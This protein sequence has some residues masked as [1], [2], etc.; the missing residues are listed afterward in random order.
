MFGDGY[1]QVKFGGHP[2]LAHRYVWGLLRGS[3]SADCVLHHTC[4]NRA[5]VNP[6]H[7]V[8]MTPAEHMAMHNHDRA[9][10]DR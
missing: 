10:A 8:V 3:I 2:Q 5:C 9:A 6:A 7:L 1:G 4:H